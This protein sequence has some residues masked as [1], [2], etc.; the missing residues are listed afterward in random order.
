[1]DDPAV[2]RAE[3]ADEERGAD[4]DEETLTGFEVLNTKS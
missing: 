3:L 2:D 4:A 1:M